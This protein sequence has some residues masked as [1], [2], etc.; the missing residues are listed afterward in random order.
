[1][2]VRLR[3]DLVR[4][5][6]DRPLGGRDGSALLQYLAEAQFKMWGTVGLRRH[7][8]TAKPALMSRWSSARA[9]PVE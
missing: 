8:G 7:D 4:D 3:H 9:L 1:M 6:A 5:R 2:P